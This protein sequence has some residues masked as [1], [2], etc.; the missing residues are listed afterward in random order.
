MMTWMLIIMI[1]T[2][3]IVIIMTVNLTLYTNTESILGMLNF[4]H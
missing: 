2:I 3:I 1:T 4:N